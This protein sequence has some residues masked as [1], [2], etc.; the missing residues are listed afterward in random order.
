ME[1]EAGSLQTVRCRILP[2]GRMTRAD[3]AKY[4]GREPKTL[5]MW[6]LEG[7]GPRVVRVGGRC[8]YYKS[9]LD[10]FIRGEAA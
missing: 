7:K 1:V 10:A 8:F 9:D 3:A 5:A 6:K 2:D 4:L